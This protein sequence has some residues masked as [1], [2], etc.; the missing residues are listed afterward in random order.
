MTKFYPTQ[1][2]DGQNIALASERAKISTL[3]GAFPFPPWGGSVRGR[4]WGGFPKQGSCQYIFG[5]GAMCCCR[6]GLHVWKIWPWAWPS[7]PKKK[8]HLS[9]RKIPMR[10]K[11]EKQVNTRGRNTRCHHFF[12]LYNLFIILRGGGI[13]LWKKISCVSENIPPVAAA[14][15][16]TTTFFEK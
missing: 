11:L 3:G 4:P 5:G 2:L 9:K 14:S 8:F 12:L 7:R 13:A 15:H 10:P 16:H 6:A 1:K